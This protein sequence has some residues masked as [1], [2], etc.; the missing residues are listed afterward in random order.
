MIFWG[1]YCTKNTKNITFTLFFRKLAPTDIFP[2][3]FWYLFFFRT[4]QAQ[5]RPLQLCVFVRSRHILD[6]ILWKFLQNTLKKWF[7]ST[8]LTKYPHSVLSPSSI[9]FFLGRQVYSSGTYP[10]I[11]NETWWK[12]LW[13]KG[14]I[15]WKYHFFALF[16]EICF[17]NIAKFP[18][19]S[20]G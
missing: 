17:K 2:D 13:K 15:H 9:F 7:F 14:K 1:N 16:F 3:I 12:F 5:S 8:T 10:T 11:L 4:L 6:D 20:L 19:I 18:Q